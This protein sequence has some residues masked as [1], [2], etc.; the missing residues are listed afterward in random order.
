MIRRTG[1]ALVT[2]LALA[3]ASVAQDYRWETNSEL[4]IAFQ[5]YKKLSQVP[6]QIGTEGGNQVQRFEPQDPGDYIYGRFGTYNWQLYVYDFGDPPD[7]VT[8]G[9]A[10]PGTGGGGETREDAERQARL[11]QLRRR[12][13]TSLRDWIE[14][15]DPGRDDTRTIVVEAKTRAGSS[16]RPTSE[17]WEYYDV[18]KVRGATGRE[19]ELIWYMTACAYEVNGRQVALIC[20]LPVKSGTKPDSKW[21]RI[22]KTMVGS[23]RFAEADETGTD[24]ERDRYAITD[25]QKAELDRLKANIND[26]D[27]WDYFTTPRFIVTF[28]WKDVQDRPKMIRFAHFMADE[29]EN[30]REM[31]EEHYPPHEGM[32]VHYSVL[33]VCA[34]YEEFQKYGSTPYG[35]IGWFSPG[36]KE[37]CVFYDETRQFGLDEDDTIAVTYHECWHQYSD[38][39]WP[40]VELH[41]WFD[42]GLAEYF[43]AWRKKGRRWVFRYHEGRYEAITRQMKDGTYIP[44]REIRAWHKDKF[45]GPR[46]SDHYA[47]AWAMVDFLKRGADKLG[48]RFDP[49]WTHILE[50]YAR[51]CLEEKS[52]S[53]AAE[54]A[55]EG[56]DM[57]AFD[58]AWKMWVDRGYIKKD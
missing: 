47:Q 31:F 56:V 3:T 53:K 45:Y 23:V 15:K 33:R 4:G 37:L 46:A 2:V 35:V 51:I 42:E 50:T 21:H 8:G 44:T 52:D 58:E 10:G 55:F 40:G 7:S 41:R 28:S 12:R 38:Q 57:E 29:L 17:W 20:V 14:N 24:D 22:A 19:E 34:T 11:E 49:S 27:N 18:S 36:T 43:G 25:E 48:K 1:L 39:Y 6:M 5:V 54:Q 16:K 30:I 13:A 26:L 9:S 32:E